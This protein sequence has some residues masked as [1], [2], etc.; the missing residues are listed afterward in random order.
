[1]DLIFISNY[2][3]HHQLHFCD[4]LCK[5]LNG[6]FIFLQTEELPPERKAMGWGGDP[7]PS[8]VKNCQDFPDVSKQIQKADIV[9]MGD[10]PEE[11]I[12]ARLLADRPTFRYS[13][14][15]YKEGQ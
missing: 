12:Q 8:Y 6:D 14:R 15:I 9:I 5:K 1:M 3:N 11:L 2:M 10:A 4:A 7:L 13:E